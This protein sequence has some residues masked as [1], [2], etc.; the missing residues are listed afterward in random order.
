MSALG[1][2]ELPGLDFYWRQRKDF[3]QPEFVNWVEELRTREP[4]AELKI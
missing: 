1:R 4:L 3:F 2:M